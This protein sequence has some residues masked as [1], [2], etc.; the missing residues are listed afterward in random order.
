MALIVCPHCGKSVSDTLSECIHCG[1]SLI[2]KDEKQEKRYEQLSSAEQNE[3]FSQFSRE[4]PQYVFPQGRE[5]AAKNGKYH[6]L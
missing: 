4:Y 1:K 5:K 6:P 3:L 2:L